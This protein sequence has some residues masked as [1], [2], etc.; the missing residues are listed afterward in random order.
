M[1]RDPEKTRKH[2]LETA[3]WE[4]FRN[5]FNGV[6]I[7]DI[8]S[9]T[10][11]TKGAFY[12]YFPTKNDLGYTIVDEMLIDMTL[13]RWVKPLAAYRN[14]VQGILSNLR[15]KIEESSNDSLGLGCPLNNLIQEMSSINPAFRE[16]LNAVLELWISEIEK[17]L[18]KAQK[19]GYL[20]KSANPRQVSEFVVTAHEGAFGMS[21][22]Y[23]DKKLFWSVY[24]ALW[25]YLNTIGTKPYSSN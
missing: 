2:I 25:D 16:K 15:K 21:K 4:I 20:K 5:G 24:H 13:D 8:I 1:M 17:Y 6:S 22:S 9:K 12:H 11:V 19:D 7:N 18:K 10:R 3:F 14:P 23:R